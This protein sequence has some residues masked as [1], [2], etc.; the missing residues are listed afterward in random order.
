M[1][2]P[3]LKDWLVMNGLCPG[4][5]DA[6]ALVMAGGV[7]VNDQPAKPGQKI[8]PDDRVRLKERPLPY[9]A[10]GGLKL[11][12]ALRAFG[13]RAKGRA[14]LDAGAST[15]GFTDCLLK[16]GASLVFAVDVGFGQLTGAL[17]Q[18]S[19]VVNLEKTNISD[20]RLKCLSPVPSLATCDLS[21][22]SLRDAMPVYR[23][24]L[25]GEGDVIALVKPLFEV[26]DPL[27]RRSGVLDES[28][29]E[30]M[31]RDLI[32]YL[33]SAGGLT[34]L[35]ACPSP[36][37]GNGGTVEF[38]LH[39]RAGGQGTPPGLDDKIRN[40]VRQALGTQIYR[41]SPG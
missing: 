10:K 11:E 39:I 29:Y 20:P 40:S 15:G 21:Y 9:A 25:H 12:G 8:R 19:R 30:P 28:A 26:D 23:D 41:R 18:D 38:F 34:V 27:A 31:L 24:I 16:H 1:N 13:V 22:L 4:A 6:A 2:R 35:D 36:V 37:T 7:L 3:P 14:C 5:K 32:Y 33:N 17:R